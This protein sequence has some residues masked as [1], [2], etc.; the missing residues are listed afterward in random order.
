M[1]VEVGAVVQEEEMAGVLMV[2][3]VEHQFLDLL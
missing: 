1:W 3:T 2:L